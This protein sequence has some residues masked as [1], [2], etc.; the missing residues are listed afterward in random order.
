[1]IYFTQTAMDS[2]LKVV[3]GSPVETGGV[4]VG[5]S[6][7]NIV[8][9]GAGGPGKDSIREITRFSN[10][11][12][13]D[14]R[15]LR[16]F[17]KTNGYGVVVVGGYHLHPG[18]MKWTSSIDLEQALEILKKF[19]DDTP[20]LVGIFIQPSSTPELFL[21]VI[22]RSKPAF[23][24]VEYQ[25]VSDDDDVVLEARRSTPSV[26]EI[27]EQVDFW[28]QESFQSV[29][30]VVGRERLKQDLKE[31]K[32][33]DWQAVLGRSRHSGACFVSAKRDRFEFKAV[34]PCE[35][36]LNPPKLFLMDGTQFFDLHSLSQWS[37]SSSLLDVFTE[38]YSI[39]LCP[40]CKRRHL[41]R[42]VEICGL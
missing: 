20:L 12:K 17:R 29:E 39:V 41:S 40:C 13:E 1:M 7:P 30:S 4:L 19:N 32:E 42:E 38:C 28:N 23:E 31:L 2:M 34:L 18:S 8:V 26:L 15:I 6:S 3:D 24:L 11:P 5:F 33:V 10:D 37:S 35:Y 36:P 9:V 14:Y 22:S 25:V 27:P 16:E 21:Y